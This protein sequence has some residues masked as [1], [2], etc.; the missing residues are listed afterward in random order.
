[1]RPW[2]DRFDAFGHHLAPEGAGQPDDA[3]DDGQVFRVFKHVADEGLVYF[4]VSACS[5]LR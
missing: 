4:Q 3:V 5:C 2:L 1:M